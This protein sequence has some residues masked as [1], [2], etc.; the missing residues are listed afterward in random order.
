M[1]GLSHNS[2]GFIALLALSVLVLVGAPEAQGA[3]LP[4]RRKISWR[5]IGTGIIKII[6]IPIG[7]SSEGGS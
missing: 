4:M 2:Y 6:W 5:S 3:V 1:R 7:I